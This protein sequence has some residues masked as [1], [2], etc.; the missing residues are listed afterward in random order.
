MADATISGVEAKD[1]GSSLVQ[2]KKLNFLGALSAVVDGSDPEQVNVDIGGG[3]PISVQAVNDLPED[4]RND[5]QKLKLTRQQSVAADQGEIVSTMSAHPL[6][7]RVSWI[8][9]LDLLAV[10]NFIGVMV[11]P[12][13]YVH[14]E[15]PARC[16]LFKER[17]GLYNPVEALR[18][19][20]VYTDAFLALATPFLTFFRRTRKIKLEELRDPGFFF[21]RYAF[22]WM[23][24]YMDNDEDAPNAFTGGV[25]RYVQKLANF[26]WLNWMESTHESVPVNFDEER[27]FFGA[28][29]VASTAYKA[30][31]S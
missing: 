5:L 8:A 2:A 16:G 19:E 23:Q 22:R 14:P 11:D 25:W 6:W 9:D 27:F 18:G 20:S 12:T 1:S 15:D 3:V 30:A 28:K 10:F 21:L 24:H 4:Q 26:I 29:D 31:V 17:C 13:W 7:K